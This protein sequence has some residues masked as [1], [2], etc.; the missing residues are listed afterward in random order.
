MTN[1]EYLEIGRFI[2]NNYVPKSGQS[3]TVQGE[4]LRAS[5]KL[6]DEAHRNGNM[7]WDSG[8]EILANYIRST[9]CDSDALPKETIEQ[10]KSDIEIVLKYEEPY[11]EDDVFDR[12]ERTIFDWYIINKEPIPR[13]INPDLHR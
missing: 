9:L 5:E 3:E 11:T 1:D 8:H 4:L 2:W 12:I 13:E 10:L 6:R 7:N